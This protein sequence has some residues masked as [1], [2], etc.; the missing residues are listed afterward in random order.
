[1]TKKIRKK[2]KVK[3]PSKVVS[4]REKLQK[5]YT[6]INLET[7]CPGHCVC[8]HIACPQM[9]YSEFLV[10]LDRIYNHFPKETRLYIL[11]K[12]IKYFF[13]QSIVKPCP[14]L[15]NKRCSCYL[16]RPL[17]CR[18]YGL[19]PEDVYEERV[20]RFMSVTG[21]KREE[22]PL[23]TQC[24]YVKRVDDSKPLTKEIIEGLYQALNDI[25]ISVERYTQEQVD[26]KYN[27]RTFHDWFVVTVFGEDNIADMSKFFLAAE[28]KE[29]VDDFVAKMLDQVDLVGD[30]VFKRLS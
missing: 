14:L 4:L 5:V 9:N 17:S 22:I 6:Y 21:M 15:D 23:N 30:K 27:Q 1:M 7:T 8:C 16:D 24:K 19:W 2:A 28:T 26:K 10:I 13:S 12:S 3:V 29:I 25:D 11:K 20:T 18:I